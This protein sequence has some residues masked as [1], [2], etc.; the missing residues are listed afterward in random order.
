M[1][2]IVIPYYKKAFFRECLESL[3]QQTNQ[4]FN[5]YIGNDA[6]PEDPTELIEEY[7]FQLKIE[8]KRFEKNLGGISLT[9]QWDRCLQLVRDEEWIMILG[10][11]DVLGEQVVASWYQSLKEVE[12]KTNVFRFATVII[13]AQSK[14]VSTKFTHPIWEQSVDSFY[15]RFTNR[16]RS[17]LSEHIFRKNCYLKYGFYNFPLAWHSDDRAWLDFSEGKSILTI[18]KATVFIRNSALNISGKTDNFEDKINASILFYEYLITQKKRLFTNK[19]LLEI[20]RSRVNL[21]LRLRDLSLKERVA[22]VAIHLRHPDREIYKRTVE[23][24]PSDLKSLLRR[25]IK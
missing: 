2:A 21:I 16:T 4:N 25:W 9:Q 23:K 22:L 15:R 20:A 3:A 5:L 19:Q 14:S 1:L 13:D 10:D 6:S 8:Y 7:K 11:D 12:K 17:S 18:N 24:L